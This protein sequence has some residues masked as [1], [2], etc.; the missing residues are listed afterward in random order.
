MRLKT[1]SPKIL[2]SSFVLAIY[3][4]GVGPPLSMVCVPSETPLKELI[5]L[6][7]QLVVNWR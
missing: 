7:E 4:L 5:S 6:C 2:L 1:K 3:L